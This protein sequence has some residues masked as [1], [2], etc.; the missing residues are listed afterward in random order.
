MPDAYC[1]N[2]TAVKN[3]IPFWQNMLIILEF[4]DVSPFYRT[5]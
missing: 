1:I 2:V 3:G 5:A 4:F